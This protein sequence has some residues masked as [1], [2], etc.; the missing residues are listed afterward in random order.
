MEQSIV[1]VKEDELTFIL[2]LRCTDLITA[3]GNNW[4]REGE[5]ELSDSRLKTRIIRMSNLFCEGL[6]G[7]VSWPKFL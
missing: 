4:K 5:N 2:G 6:M 7:L 3:S 1:N